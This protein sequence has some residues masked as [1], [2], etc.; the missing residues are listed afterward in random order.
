MKEVNK[1]FIIYRWVEIALLLVGLALV[2]KFKEPLN[3]SITWGGNNF[4]YGFGLFLA[5]QSAVMLGA[6]YFAEKRALHYTKL[7]N[8]FVNKK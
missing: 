5:I 7:L 2:F 1:N 8:E 6:D 3:T 4:W